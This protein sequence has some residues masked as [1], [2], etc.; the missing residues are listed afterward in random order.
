MVEWI[1]W[2]GRMIEC[3]I[4]VNDILYSNVNILCV[5]CFMC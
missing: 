3:D 1:E 4:F 5:N 2:N